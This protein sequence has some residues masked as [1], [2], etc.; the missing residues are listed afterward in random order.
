MAADP[1]R[2]VDV[3]GVHPPDGRGDVF[4]E[5]GSGLLVT[6]DLVLTA[7]HVVFDD[8]R[9]LDVELRCPSWD[10][11]VPGV[12]VWPRVRGDVDA[13]LVRVSDPSLLG[14]LGRAPRFG[15]FTS[16]DA[17]QRV[18]ATGFPRV[19][20]ERGRRVS[21]QLVGHV[22]PQG[23]R[24]EG[25]YLVSVED[26]PAQ[27]GAG[28]ASPWSGMSGAAVFSGGILVGIIVIDTPGFDRD[29][30]TVV[31]ASV[32]ANDAE[33]RILL[34]QSGPLAS[35]ELDRVLSRP[36]V[37]RGRLSPAQLLRADEEVI[38]FSGRAAE[39][40]EL[41]HWCFSDEEFG[42]RLVVGPGGRGKTRMAQYLVAQVQQEHDEWLAGLLALNLGSVG[43]LGSLT[44]T[45]RSHP[46]LLVADY[47]ESRG[48]QLESL[49]H[50]YEQA[51]SPPRM[52]LL[53]LAR[54]EGDWWLRLRDRHY[55]LLGDAGF[56]SLPPLH[57]LDDR[58]AAFNGSVA[59]FARRL[60]GVYPGVDWEAVAAGI[61]AEGLNDARFGDPLS[62]QL[63]ALLSL[64]ESGGKEV[65][66]ESVEKLEDRLIG[67][68]RDYW[69]K[70]L[71]AAGLNLSD[72]VRD[73]AVAAATLITVG[74][75]QAA[76]GLLQRVPEL[77]EHGKVAD[78][79][80]SL[81]PTETSSRYFG[82]LQPDRVGEHHV[83]AVTRAEP[84]LLGHLL[85][86]EDVGELQEALI[87]IGRAMPHQPHLSAQV[88]Q[89][90]TDGPAV[91]TEAVNLA[92]NLI[93]DPLPLLRLLPDHLT[94]TRY[95]I[96][97]DSY[98][99]SSAWGHTAS[100]PERLSDIGRGAG[101]NPYTSSHPFTDDLAVEPARPVTR[102]GLAPP[103]R[104]ADDLARGRD[105]ERAGTEAYEQGNLVRANHEFGRA[106]AAFRSSGQP[107]HIARTLL[108]HAA[109]SSDLR[110]FVEASRMADEAESILRSEVAQGGMDLG[111][112]G[113][114][115]DL[116]AGVLAE[117]GD[118]TFAM[119]AQYEAV[120]LLRDAD[121]QQR[122]RESG[123]D[124]AKS[125]SNLAAL[126][127]RSGRAHEALAQSN[128]AVAIL[129]ELSGHDLL[130]S[131]DA[132]YGRVLL[133][134]ARIIA[135]TQGPDAAVEHVNRA[136][137]GLQRVAA[138]GPELRRAMVPEMAAA[139]EFTCALLSQLGR[140]TEALELGVTAVSEYEDLAEWSPGFVTDLARTL[141]AVA[142][143][144]LDLGQA[145]RAVQDAQRAVD[146]LESIETAPELDPQ[147]VSRRADEL[148]N[149]HG[150][151][152]RAKAAVWE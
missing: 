104:V 1:G 32:V 73:Q 35:V 67:H 25:R 137:A 124:L 86:S 97:P 119:S 42:A 62:L 108:A 26:P 92:A 143:L 64:L 110:A 112:L 60:P 15:R 85:G 100:V 41:R 139:H 23:A 134:H 53:L 54:D 46:I 82:P 96:D 142:A 66:E 18:D 89:L 8:E 11:P 74:T 87:I 122:S 125:L 128:E 81:Y 14:D 152:A 123:R 84:T 50:A 91:L 145:P 56:M 78:W 109:V 29:L 103:D 48:P 106:V 28:Q 65:V 44:R 10:G 2:L 39:L 80:R 116:H 98:G 135:T 63:K 69:R 20:L 120:K 148:R 76:L 132:T 101:G 30:L 6:D 129:G 144:R 72:R 75:R 147:S 94:H 22:N 102:G 31:P 37:S 36:A 51:D 49:L 131:R 5:L 151:L 127:Q 150:T 4:D 33:A 115:L 140:R 141:A 52:R 114:A 71:D 61:R 47:S 27:P 136:I 24:H 113:R 16:R 121:D 19:M 45:T 3:R 95:T 118:L 58:E 21:F 90:V 55:D 70:T 107:A 126:M 9:P 13:A 40:D 146:L 17:D 88:K 149:A 77:T 138:E 7:A 12:V 34:Q 117:M 83:G 43:D 79:L 68:E 93:P 133:G 130:G 38:T 105:H 99:S 57:A 59:Q 111:V